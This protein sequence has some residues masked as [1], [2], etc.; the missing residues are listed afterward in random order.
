MRRI[1]FKLKQKKL[2][3]K[4][5]NKH[6]PKSKA[7]ERDSTK[8]SSYLLD[9]NENVFGDSPIDEPTTEFEAAVP[10]DNFFECFENS[11]VEP[12]VEGEVSEELKDSLNL[13]ECIIR[14]KV[15][16]LIK[17]K[18]EAKH[19]A[20]EIDEEEF[21]ALEEASY[22]RYG[23]NCSDGVRWF[24]NYNGNGKGRRN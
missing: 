15:K 24:Q 10:T 22:R 14:T 20:I 8:S 21:K 7:S 11:E 9:P 4:Q 1:S 18:L 23:R 13:A 6:N 3:R 5:R 2:E 16:S 19:E 17:S 12:N